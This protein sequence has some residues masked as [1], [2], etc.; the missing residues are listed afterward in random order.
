MNEPNCISDG[1]SRE[2]PS[3][4]VGRLSAFTAMAQDQSLMGELRSHRPHGLAKINKK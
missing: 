4:P 2:F 1:T 3:G